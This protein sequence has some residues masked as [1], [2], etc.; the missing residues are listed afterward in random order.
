M[1][2]IGFEIKKFDG[3]QDLSAEVDYLGL[4]KISLKE[5]VIRIPREKTENF[6]GF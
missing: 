2:K 4:D 5:I 1:S 6:I 3:K